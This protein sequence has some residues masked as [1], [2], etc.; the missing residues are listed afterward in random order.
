MAYDVK[1]VTRRR[2]HFKGNTDVLRNCVTRY[3]L[4]CCMIQS[5]ETSVTQPNA[6]SSTLKVYRNKDIIIKTYPLTVRSF[7]NKG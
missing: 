4:A 2:T 1:E 3:A 7:F 5:S 6:F